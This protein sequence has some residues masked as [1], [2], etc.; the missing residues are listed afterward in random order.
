[1][2]H[3]KWK[4]TLLTLITTLLVVYVVPYIQAQLLSPLPPP[5]PGYYRVT[6]DADGDTIEVDMSGVT[7]R[8]RLIGV[9]TPETHKPNTPVQC[10]G[11]EASALTKA[12]LGGKTVRLEADRTGDNRDRYNRLLRYVYTEDGTLWNKHLIEQG[13][14]F[15]YT[16]FTFTK[17]GEFIQAQSAALAAKRGLWTA[18]QPR[19]IDGRWQTNTAGRTGL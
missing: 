18:C 7:E 11:P 2:S 3:T 5:A 4:R 10:Y 8:I 14:G 15:A 6:K 12:A 9:D 16:Q 17:K 1:M 13:A 19:N